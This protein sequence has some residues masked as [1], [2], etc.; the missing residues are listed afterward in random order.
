MEPES[1]DFYAHTEVLN[2]KRRAAKVATESQEGEFGSR[3]RPEVV[4]LKKTEVSVTI[5]P[6]RIKN[7]EVSR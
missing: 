1:D 3:E 4:N 2:A 5:D 7:G 6:A